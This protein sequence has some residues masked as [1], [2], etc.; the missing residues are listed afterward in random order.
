MKFTAYNKWKKEKNA[1]EVEKLTGFNSTEFEDNLEQLDLIGRNVSREKEF[2]EISKQTESLKQQ[3]E[4]ILPVVE[5][6]QPIIEDKKLKPIAPKVAR[7]S[8]EERKAELKLE[9]NE[10]RPVKTTKVTAQKKLSEE[11]LDRK[12][13]VAEIMNRPKTQKIEPVILAEEEKLEPAIETRQVEKEIPKITV[14]ESEQKQEEVIQEEPAVGLER[15][16]DPR[17][18]ELL[19]RRKALREILDNTHNITLEWEKVSSGLKAISREDNQKYA[20]QYKQSMSAFESGYDNYIK[21]QGEQNIEEKREGLKDYAE[22]ITKA[23]DF[24]S[25]HNETKIVKYEKT[26]KRLADISA[27]RGEDLS[28]DRKAIEKIYQKWQKS[29]SQELR[30]QYKKAVEM[31][32]KDLEHYSKVGDPNAN[33][34]SEFGDHLELMKENIANASKE[35]NGPSF[36]FQEDTA[37][38][39]EEQKGADFDVQDN[40]IPEERNVEEDT[41][42]I[43]EGGAP[44]EPE[45]REIVSTELENPVIEDQPKNQDINEEIMTPKA[46]EIL[47]PEELYKT[48]LS[49]GQLD[50]TNKLLNLQTKLEEGEEQV[51]GL[52][53][54]WLSAGSEGEVLKK[55]HDEALA[56]LKKEFEEYDVLKKANIGELDRISSKV[57][58]YKERSRKDDYISLPGDDD[59]SKAERLKKFNDQDF[60]D[61]LEKSDLKGRILGSQN[62]LLDEAKKLDDLS[63]DKYHGALSKLEKKFAEYKGFKEERTDIDIVTKFNDEQFKRRLNQFSLKGEAL[64]KESELQDLT[65]QMQNLYVERVSGNDEAKQTYSTVLADLSEKFSEYNQWANEHKT[66][67]EGFSKECEDNITQFNSLDEGLS[68]QKILLDLEDEVEELSKNGVSDEYKVALEHLQEN[69]NEYEEWK[70]SA[71]PAIENLT[72]FSSEKIQ[73]FLKEQEAKLH[74]EE[75]ELQQKELLDLVAKVEDLSGLLAQN[76]ESVEDEY[77]STLEQLVRKRGEYGEW[78]GGQN[79]KES[80]DF[81]EFEER[82]EAIG[83]DYIERYPPPQDNVEKVENILSDDDQDEIEKIKSTLSQVKLSAI[84]PND[85]ENLSYTS[86]QRKFK[87]KG[88]QR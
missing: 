9:M 2:Q 14:S 68:K 32:D 64:H 61:N 17:E 67:S 42:N 6:V 24:L 85:K 23:G 21:W 10:K 81:S 33:K 71:P 19:S 47:D 66:G 4:D 20:E 54:N 39:P 11:E 86:P 34:L 7:K 78:K 76:D 60:S 5:E 75:A 84:S 30:N 52:Y 80:E 57:Q 79:I 37:P 51:L 50:L 13:L 1:E 56:D 63:G 88:E 74:D 36:D 82:F 18:A 48:T 22:Q 29:P 70:A 28:K 58:Q 15:Q 46:S 16:S 59:L 35:Q 25:Q 26:Q 55:Q 43:T 8:L 44:N 53:K 12:A 40:P 77:R 45:Q 62:E 73:D 3:I 65:D 87:N 31:F 72:G 69:L 38:T 41:L 83:K 49:P 27:R